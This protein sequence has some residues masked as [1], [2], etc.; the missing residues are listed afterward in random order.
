MHDMGERFSRVSLYCCRLMV[1]QDLKLMMKLREYPGTYESDK[2]TG[3][4][5][6]LADRNIP[7]FCEQ[8][9][10]KSKA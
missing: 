1:S 10:S 2:E 3:K 9:R 4:S 7:Q 8:G 5:S 6:A